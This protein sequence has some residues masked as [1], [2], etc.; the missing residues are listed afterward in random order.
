MDLRANTAV[1]VLI[2]PFVDST[3]GNTTEDGL[4]L[5][6]A[7][8]KLSKNGQSLTQKN[9]NTAAAFDDD[10]YYNC[11]LDSTDTDTEGQLV[12]IVH[13]SGALPV[14]HEY[15][16]LAEAA[17]DSLY[18]PKD[19]GYM[20]VNIKTVGRADTQETEANNLESACSNYSATR[21]LTG[22]AVPAVAAGAAGGIPTDTDSNGA[23]RIVD[24]T[25]ARELNTSSG[26]VFADIVMVSA[27]TNAANNLQSQYD[28]TGLTG[29]TFPATQ[30]QIGTLSTGSAGI[31]TTAASTEDTTPSPVGNPTN[32]Y[33][34]TVQ[35]DGT[36]HSW[37]DAG[38]ELEF[39][40]NFN[41]GANASPT[42][43]IWHGFAQANNDSIAVYARNWVGVSWEQIGTI[44]GTALATDQEQTFNLT[45]AHVNTGANSGDVRIRFV[46][47]GGTIITN[48]ATDQ[49]LCGFTI[50]N[51][52]VGYANGAI[53][54]NTNA[55]NTNTV[56]YVDGVAD[57]PVSTWAAALT[58][59]AS[60]SINK[61][62]IANGSTIQLSANTDNKVLCGE[63]WTLQLNSQ[64]CASASFT[65]ADVTGI[66]T[67]SGVVFRDCH[68]AAGGG[69]MSFAGIEAHNCAIAGDLTMTAANSYF[70]DQCYSA[71]AGT[72][73]PS[74]DFEDANE[75]KNLNFRH[76]SGGIEIK[77]IGQAGSTDNISLEG[78]GQLIIASTCEAATIAIRGNFTITDNV[79]GGGF[80]DGAGG[81][82]SDDARID[83]QQINDECD[84]ALSDYDGPTN[85]EMV[86]AFTEIKG[87]TWSSGTDT[88]E[89]I[90]NRGDSAWITATG[91]AVAGDAMTLTAGERTTLADVI[92]VRAVQNVEDSADRHSL[93]A[94]I[95]FVTNWSISGA[96]LTAKKPSNDSTFD[97]YA[98]GTTPDVDPVTGVS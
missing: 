80:V 94:L 15:N 37:T 6:Q 33:T 66:C 81:T 59:S 55:S 39:A 72:S 24:G 73:T 8:I 79:G 38:G 35:L 30:A 32:T 22:T 53:W 48:F 1:D 56:D 98:L 26:V 41:I 14:R 77:N 74:I 46:S 28:G 52:S 47:T 51:Q 83:V 2:G 21:G 75:N 23:V 3:D 18:A 70:F 9:D 65:G 84:T 16:V 62:E 43:I 90:R 50:T 12:L 71:V 13:E 31:N 93:G 89:A 40:Y 85:T 19:A 78:W 82:L 10:G 88:L 11:E 97:T 96:T 4:T 45:I 25:G 67:G 29:D 95:M 17:W 5:A 54:I 87:T 60:L 64:S 42:S 91:F 63:E 69:T 76:Y 86:A 58:L 27:N 57:K 49:I 92:L 20:D 68:L 34:D 44:D 61:F 7:D 36:Y